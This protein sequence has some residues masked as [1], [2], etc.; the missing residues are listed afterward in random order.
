MKPLEHA[1]PVLP[2]I[3]NKPTGILSAIRRAARWYI[4]ATRAPLTEDE[5]LDVRS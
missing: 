4:A 1:V 2:A 3:D 5:K